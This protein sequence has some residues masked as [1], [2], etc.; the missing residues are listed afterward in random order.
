MKTTL[1]V[2]HIIAVA[3]VVVLIPSIRA[4]TNKQPGLIKKEF[5]FE[6]VSFAASHAST[7]VE[8]QNG[9][10]AA[11]FAGAEPRHP[12]VSIWSARYDGESWSAPV[13][14][15][16][17]RQEN[18][19]RFQCWNPVLFQPLRGPLL[20]FYKVGPK[21]EGWWGMLMTSTNAGV[22]WSKPVRLPTGFIGPVRNKPVELPDGSLLCGASTES[23]GW[24]VHMERAFQLGQRWEKTGPLNQQN[25]LGA[26]QPTILM[27]SPKTLQ[28]L[29]RTKQGSIVESWS[30]DT[31][32]TWSPMSRTSL[33]NPNSAIDA[34]RLKDG[35]F[36]LVYNHS[37]TNR[38]VL[39]VAVSEDGQEWQA[40]LVLENQPGEFSYPAVI[41]SRDG[42]VHIT[43]SWNRQRIKHAVVDP[44]RL[45][46]T[47]I[48][49]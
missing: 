31:G 11:W 34:V 43:Y 12:D 27:H 37:A 2:K 32:Q 21:P 19:E 38:N 28:I 40:A 30:K 3:C 48:V 5:V 39:N 26:I 47:P 25:V 13:E 6:R 23:D 22:T 18:G 33:P 41:Q 9:L 8:T 42:L 14:V 7:I 29:C 20:L 16:D 36:L 1:H 45:T 4:A 35:R 44:T 15:V 10:L 49:K 24:V 17:G 46:L